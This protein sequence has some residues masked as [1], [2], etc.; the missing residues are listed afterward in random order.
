[1]GAQRGQDAFEVLFGSLNPLRHPSLRCT[2]GSDHCGELNPLPTP[3]FCTCKQRKPNFG[4]ECARRREREGGDRGRA[5]RS[6][7][8]R[9]L[10]VHEKTTCFRKDDKLRCKE[11]QRP[12]KRNKKRKHKEVRNKQ[13][14]SDK[15]RRNGGGKVNKKAQREGL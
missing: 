14:T 13:G 12:K 15:S 2:S 1:M 4:P 11:S 5:T 7:S 9:V 3:P 8:P 6:P 10:F